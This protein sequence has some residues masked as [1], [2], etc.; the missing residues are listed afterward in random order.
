MRFICI[1]LINPDVACWKCNQILI[2]EHGKPTGSHSNIYHQKL[3]LLN[4]PR[5]FAM[6]GFHV[7]ECNECDLK[8]LV[9]I[10]TES[11]KT[12]KHSHAMQSNHISQHEL[13]FIRGVHIAAANAQ[14][15]LRRD[16]SVDKGKTSTENFHRSKSILCRTLKD[17]KIN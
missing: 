2:T 10:A 12:E 11:S 3:A 5:Y 6:R 4:E 14:F 16:F 15:I 8:A 9:N 7:N 17:A 1:L 13:F